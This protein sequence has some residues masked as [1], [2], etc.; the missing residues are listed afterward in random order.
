MNIRINARIRTLAVSVLLACCFLVGTSFAQNAPFG[1]LDS[2]AD[3]T[4][5][6]T[7]TPTST[8]I[9]SGWAADSD[10]FA[11]VAKVQVLIDGTTVGNA[12]LGYNRQDVATAYGAAYLPSGWNATIV[13][14]NLAVGTHTVT[15][16]ASDAT[17]LSTVLTGQMT[18]TIKAGIDVSESLGTIAGTPIAGKSLQVTDTTTNVGVLPVGLSVTRFY[19]NATAVRGGTLLGNRSFSS[20]APAAFSTAT[21]TVTLPAGVSGNYYLLACANDTFTLADSNTANNCASSMI[22]IAGADLAEVLTAVPAT[23]I[24]GSSIQIN[25]TVSNLGLGNAGLSV[26][27][28][29]LNSTAVRGGTL[30]GTRSISTLAAG[31]SSASAAT[32]LALST[33][34]TGGQYFLVACANDTFTVSEAV[35]TNNCSALPMMVYSSTK[36]VIVDAT[37]TVTPYDA[38]TCGTATAACKTI[39]DGVTKAAAGS[40]VIVYPGTYV[41]QITIAKNISL[42]SFTKNTAI[43]KAPAATK[44][45]NDADGH[46]TLLTITGGA[47]SVLVKDMTVAGPMFVDGCADLIYGIFVKNANAIISGNKIDR[48]QQLDPSQWGCQPGVG[49][50]F[51]S[52]GLSY[53]GHTGTIS[54][55]TVIGPAK[56]GI[57][58]DG[59]NTNVNVTGNTITGL[60]VV[61]VVGQNGIQISRGA[62]GT[63]DGNNISGFTY[64]S[65]MANLSAAGILVYGITG[66]VTVSNNTLYGNDE[67]IGVYTDAAYTSGTPVQVA[68]TTVIKN[69]T[70]SNNVYLGIHIDPFSKGNTIWSNTAHGNPGWDLLDEHSDLTFN[71]WWGTLPSNANIF[72]TAWIGLVFSY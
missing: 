2:A 43:L 18:I 72:D 35:S 51:G 5:K 14:N 54:N 71:D 8:L 56:G 64:G 20:L 9:V 25:E 23:V 38:T 28:F 13:L 7:M 59:T 53:I 31:T 69:N 42:V 21:T 3:N 46:E 34:I 61:G 55:N 41:E 40:T 45:T 65:T 11:P 17:L 63:V 47:T 4:G 24:T 16:V 1:Y 36:T 60:N 22:T 37:K 33:S 50:R 58:V 66:G 32:T 29:Y 67:G 10:T 30:L 6:T 70:A 48:I 49:I 27:R 52:R 44:L 39:A 26:N 12:V 57:V 62:K 15:A 19:L 68:T